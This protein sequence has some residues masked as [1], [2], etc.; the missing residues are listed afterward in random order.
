MD[1]THPLST[2]VV[3]RSLDLYKDPF[4]PIEKDENILDPKVPYLSVI[5]ALIY[6]VNCTRLNISFVVNLL[7]KFSSSS[8][9]RHWNCEIDV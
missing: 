7:A 6:L 5:D 1:K 9:K 4:R 3:V 2:S 8:M